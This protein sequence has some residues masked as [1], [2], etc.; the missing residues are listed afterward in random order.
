M[1]HLE[2]GFNATL[3]VLDLIVLAG[4]QRN[5]RWTSLALLSWAMGAFLLAALFASGA[6]F[7]RAFFAARLFSYALFAHGPLCWLALAYL[8]REGSEPAARGSKAGARGALVV[9]LALAAIGVDA[10]LI[11]PHWLQVRRVQVSSPRLQRPLRIVVLADLQ[12]DEIGDYERSVL[13]RIAEEKPDLLLLAGDYL[14]CW[15]RESL[16]RET[17]AFQAALREAGIAPRLGAFAVGGDCERR[18]WKAL[19]AGSVI[20]PLDGVAEVGSSVRVQGLSLGHSLR[21]APTLPPSERFRIVFGHRPDFALK[22]TEADLL[23]AGHTHGGQIQLPFIGPLVTLSRVPRAWAGGKPTRMPN[24][25]LLVVSRGVG[26]ERA[27]AP[28]L[29]FLCRPEL[30][31]IEVT[32]EPG[33]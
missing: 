8:L 22:S 1:L 26:M 23:L 6:P 7:M 5:R 15:D 33:P 31:V 16:E 3:A 27:T 12:T 17:L 10:F 20:Q 25:A 21:G 14:Q 9:G 19:F 24:G 2:L 18:G 30:L 13:A 28:R 4:I 11:E 29:R 32:P